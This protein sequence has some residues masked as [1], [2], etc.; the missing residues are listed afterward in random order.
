[1][2][3]FRTSKIHSSTQ[4]EDVIDVRDACFHSARGRYRR[5]RQVLPL[6]TQASD[7]RDSCIETHRKD[8]LDDVTE[9]QVAPDVRDV[10]FHSNWCRIWDISFHSNRCHIR[11]ILFYLNWRKRYLTPNRRQRHL[12]PLKK[13]RHVRGILFQS[14]WRHVEDMSF[15]ST[16]R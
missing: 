1:M 13:R 16:R 15:H 11:H 6:S 5:Q 10:S 14:K 3:P 12:N 8:V 9:R 4:H 7:V 2:F